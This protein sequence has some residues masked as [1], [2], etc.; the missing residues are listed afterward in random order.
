MYLSS[1]QFLTISLNVINDLIY[2]IKIIRCSFVEM[3]CFMWIKLTTSLTKPDNT[4]QIRNFQRLIK[5]VYI[6]LH[7][8]KY[9]IWEFAPFLKARAKFFIWIIWQQK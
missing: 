6:C 1:K 5:L 8:R 9:H 4:P 2:Q 7:M 3:V